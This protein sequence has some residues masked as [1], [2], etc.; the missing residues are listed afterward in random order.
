MQTALLRMYGKWH[1]IDPGGFDA[2]ARQVITRLAIIESRR[3]Y[4]RSGHVRFGT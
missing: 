4:Q 3:A 2:Y 1:R